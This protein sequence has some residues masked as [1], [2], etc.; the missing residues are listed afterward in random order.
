MTQL[1][2]ME[3]YAGMRFDHAGDQPTA[4]GS[5]SHPPEPDY[6]RSIK[7]HLWRLLNTRQGSVLIDPDYGVPDLTLGSRAQDAQALLQLLETVIKRYERRLERV[8]LSVVP[9]EG[10]E[11]VECRFL[12]QGLLNLSRE[13]LPVELRAAVLADG[14]CRLE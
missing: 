5:V 10:T 12:I 2:L 3:R 1:R 4:P 6:Q 9:S 14:T 8:R 13:P 11:Q 7:G